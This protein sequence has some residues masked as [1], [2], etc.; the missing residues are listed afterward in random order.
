MATRRRGSFKRSPAGR[1]AWP[2]ANEGR[3]IERDQGQLIEAVGLEYS[4]DPGARKA[5]P[6]RRPTAAR[7][8]TAARRVSRTSS[9]A[10]TAAEEVHG[11]LCGTPTA[12][13][14]EHRGALRRA[15]VQDARQGAAKKGTATQAT[16]RGSRR[17]ATARHPGPLSPQCEGGRHLPI[18]TARDGHGKLVRSRRVGSSP[19]IRRDP[20]TSSRCVRSHGGVAARTSTPGLPASSSCSRRASEGPLQSGR[21]GGHGTMR[22]PEGRGSSSQPQASDPT[23]SRSPAP[24]RRGRRQGQVGDSN[25]ARSTRRS[26]RHP[27]RPTPRSTSCARFR[28]ST[29][30]G[31]DSRKHIEIASP[32]DEE[33]DRAARQLQL[34]AVPR[35]DR[36]APA[37]EG[38]SEEKGQADYTSHPGRRRPRWRRPLR[39]RLVPGDTKV[40]RPRRSRA[41]PPAP[42]S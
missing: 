5:S 19:P 2:D 31:V 42:G 37:G 28:R 9:S 15:G 17:S 35:V 22:T 23:R 38:G 21:V 34:P 26:A 30:Q 33:S 32:D 25:V 29:S 1:H 16:G 27:R 6:T 12:R 13:Q 10:R 7:H 3:Y 36:R 40:P 11:T 41:I 20:G 4:F 24:V 18:A 39:P 8:L 14:L